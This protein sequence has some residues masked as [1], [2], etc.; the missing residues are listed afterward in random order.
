V[1]LVGDVVLPAPSSGVMVAQG[2]ALGFVAGAAISLVGGTCATLVAYFVGRRGRRLINRFVSREEQLRAATLLEAHG[3]WAIV[4]TRPVPMIAEAVA[5][6]AGASG[7]LPWW[8][9]AVAGALGNVLPA[10][11]YAAVGAYAAN[12]VNGL[13][14]FAGVCALA[15]LGWAL[16]RVRRARLSGSTCL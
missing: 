2:A 8:K 5:I 13:V 6:L 7:G 9:V 11:A 15:A 10:V 1:L 4:A 14:V 12:F 16:Q 3:M